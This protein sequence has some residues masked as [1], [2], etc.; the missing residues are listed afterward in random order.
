MASLTL[1]GCRFSSLTQFRAT[2]SE[3][4]FNC[5]FGAGCGY[6]ELLSHDVAPKF[7]LSTSFLYPRSYRFKIKTSYNIW[8]IYK[9]FQESGSRNR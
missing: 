1:L 7:A 9:Y 2:K 6:P 4:I 8:Q 3:L 5:Q